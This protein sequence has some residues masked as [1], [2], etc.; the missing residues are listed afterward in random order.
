MTGQMHI[1]ALSPTSIKGT[2]KS[3]GAE[4][5]ATMTATINMTGKWLGADCGDV[6]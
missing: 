6:K 3:S 2:I 1:E 5:G 4:Q